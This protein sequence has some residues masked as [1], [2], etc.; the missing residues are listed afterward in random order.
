MSLLSHPHSHP[1]MSFPSYQLYP[2][3]C[4]CA[5][6]PN[7]LGWG[8]GD[9]AKGIVIEDLKDRIRIEFRDRLNV[10]LDAC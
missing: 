10:K 4:H 9:S 7:E 8:E 1:A 6:M 3:A 5:Q 2:Q